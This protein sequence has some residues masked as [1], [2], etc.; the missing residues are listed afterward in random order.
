MDLNMIYSIRCLSFYLF[1]LLSYEVDVN[2]FLKVSVDSEYVETRSGNKNGKDWSM[3]SQEVWAHFVDPTGSP[4]RF[5][6]KIKIT[7]EKDAKPYKP[8][9]YFV[10]PSSFYRG[11]F[12]KLEM[13]LVLSPL[14]V[15]VA[16]AA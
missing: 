15:P 5:P 11:D 4:Q 9:D 8:G 14:A 1:I 6:S 7:L 16:K 10:N 2:P 3:T 12:D 13:R